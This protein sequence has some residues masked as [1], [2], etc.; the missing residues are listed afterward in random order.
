MTP[1]INRSIKSLLYGINEIII[2]TL[3]LRLS[4]FL[5]LINAK[6]KRP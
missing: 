4:K 1:A 6:L 3:M 2:M 5:D